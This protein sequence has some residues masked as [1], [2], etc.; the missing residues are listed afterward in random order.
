MSTDFTITS[1]DVT[2]WISNL[3]SD[4]AKNKRVLGA[5]Q[6]LDPVL[7][8]KILFYLIKGFLNISKLYTMDINNVS[9]DLL[10]KSL[11]EENTTDID[12]VYFYRT[13]IKKLAGFNVFMKNLK[14]NTVYQISR[15]TSVINRFLVKVEIDALGIDSNKYSS[16]VDIRNDYNKIINSQSNK[17][18]INVINTKASVLKNSFGYENI[19][20]FS[21]AVINKVN[22]YA[23][24]YTNDITLPTQLNNADIISWIIR[25]SYL[26]TEYANF[27]ENFNSILVSM[28]ENY[29][30]DTAK[31]GIDTLKAL[32]NEY[33]W[34]SN[35]NADS[36]VNSASFFN[37]FRFITIL[38]VAVIKNIYGNS[39]FPKT[40]IDLIIN[41]YKAIID[42]FESINA[43]LIN[44]LNNIQITFE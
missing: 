14:E 31:L 9:V 17:D 30:T 26:D 40:D 12:K 28:A 20:Y 44:F 24:I 41:E 34:K 36:F 13:A 37:N 19:E 22:A 33:S 38:K 8:K 42:Y 43:Y 21:N 6:L 18:A 1:D 5:I 3:D 10:V 15:Q 25:K 2:L 23:L 32:N 27:L 11:N 7:M 39:N 4:D 29:D 35:F 16:V